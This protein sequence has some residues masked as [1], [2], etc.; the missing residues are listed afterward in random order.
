MS[1]V[2]DLASRRGDRIVI[3]TGILKSGDPALNGR[4]T[5]WLEYHPAYGGSVI[6]WDGESLAEARR[7]AAEWAATGAVVSDRTGMPS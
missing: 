2:I 5:F 1:N 6:T 3:E 7:A 4:R